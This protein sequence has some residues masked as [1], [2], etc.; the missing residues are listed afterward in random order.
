VARADFFYDSVS[1]EYYINEVQG[2]V[3]TTFF[4]R[5]HEQEY[6]YLTRVVT[7]WEREFIK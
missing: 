7:T 3:G 5:I 6:D 2:M 4:A 1:D